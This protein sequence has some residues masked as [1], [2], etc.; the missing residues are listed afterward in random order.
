MCVSAC[1]VWF[2]SVVDTCICLRVRV[3]VVVVDVM[4]A[5]VGGGLC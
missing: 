4:Q 3:V 5:C 1:G 2:G